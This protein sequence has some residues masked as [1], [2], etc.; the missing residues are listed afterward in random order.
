MV[1]RCADDE[2]KHEDLK[3]TWKAHGPRFQSCTHIAVGGQTG[4]IMILQWENFRPLASIP[5]KGSKEGIC[6]L[7]FTPA[8]STAALLAA[9]SND[10]NI[11][12]YNVAHGYQCVSCFYRTPWGCFIAF[13]SSV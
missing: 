1:Q 12:I 8:G 13:L 6:D 5:A 3:S 10:Q 2:F 9:A 7:K 11:Y 4:R